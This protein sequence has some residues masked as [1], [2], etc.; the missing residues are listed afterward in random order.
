M[1]ISLNEQE[2]TQAITEYLGNSVMSLKGKTVSVEFDGECLIDVESDGESK[3]VVKATRKRR[4]R[5][6][7]PVVEEKV[8]TPKSVIES[9]PEPEE[10]KE[11]EEDE[12]TVEDVVDTLGQQLGDL[13][14]PEDDLFPAQESPKKPGNSIFA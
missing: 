3:P 2:I 1:Q 4:T 7:E 12:V 8:E 9:T 11:K 6:P 10:T 14:E 5:K 13:R